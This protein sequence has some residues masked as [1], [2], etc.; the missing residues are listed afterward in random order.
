MSEAAED[1][2][3]YIASHMSPQSIWRMAKWYSGSHCK[4]MEPYCRAGIRISL[5]A[6]KAQRFPV[7]LKVKGG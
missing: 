5:A 3:R 6:L 1:A 2:I 4:E 7:K